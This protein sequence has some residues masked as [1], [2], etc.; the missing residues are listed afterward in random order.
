MRAIV[1]VIGHDRVG[2]IAAVSTTLSRHQVN[3]LDIRQTVMQEYFTMIMLVDLAAMSLSF[4]EL[5]AALNATGE[6][7]G[8]DVRIQREE[9]FQAMHHV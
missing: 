6:Q 1:T 5:V 4:P 3:I 2:I 9:T 8:V 7:L